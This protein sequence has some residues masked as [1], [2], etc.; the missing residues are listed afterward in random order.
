[1]IAMIAMIQRQEGGRGLPRAAGG[2][3]EPDGFNREQFLGNASG[4]KPGALHFA[5]G[6]VAAST[7][8]NLGRGAATSQK[9]GRAIAACG[10]RPA[11]ARNKALGPLGVAGRR[12]GKQEAPSS[13]VAVFKS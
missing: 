2:R 13:P 11:R 6:L 5:V 7:N 12:G 3:V 4:R 10:E 9:I 1:M 8:R